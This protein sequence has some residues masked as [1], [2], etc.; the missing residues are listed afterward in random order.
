[1]GNATATDHRGGRID[2][3]LSG[4]E[5]VSLPPL[6]EVEGAWSRLLPMEI[7]RYSVIDI[8]GKD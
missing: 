7:P 5:R 8:S 2:Y 6:G 3:H 1:M 4:Q